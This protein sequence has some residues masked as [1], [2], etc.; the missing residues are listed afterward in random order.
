[1]CSRHWMTRSWEVSKVSECYCEYDCFTMEENQDEFRMW[2]GLVGPTFFPTVD[3]NGNISWTNNGG[4]PNPATQNIRGPEGH[5][6]EISGIVA[7][8]SE[9]PVSAPQGTM[10]AVGT[11][12]PYDAYCYL[13]E[14]VNLG[15]IFP[16]GPVGPQGPIGITPNLQIGTVETGDTGE[17]AEASITGTPENPLLN[18]KLPKGDAATAEAHI[19]DH[20]NNKMWSVAQEVR[21]GFLIE[22]FTEVIT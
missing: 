6:C 4:L 3:A 17:P 20:D 5:G 18:L 15:L 13:G 16:Q 19:N 8:A 1:M 12:E 22:T 10:Y 21:D 11:E 2:Q 7:S 14:W 9:L